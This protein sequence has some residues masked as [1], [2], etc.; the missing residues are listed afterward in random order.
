MKSWQLKWKPQAL[1][2]L[3]SL[4]NNSA[5]KNLITQTIHRMEE[6]LRRNPTAYGES[7]KGLQ[8]MAFEKPLCINFEVIPDDEKVIVISVRIF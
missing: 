3:A 7:R 2:E 1:R 5:D 4:Y 6:T 8:R